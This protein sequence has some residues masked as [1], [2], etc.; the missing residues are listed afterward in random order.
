MEQARAPKIPKE[1]LHVA[2]GYAAIGLVAHILLRGFSFD[3]TSTL[4]YVLGW[5][6][7]VALSL[8]YWTAKTLLW[9]LVPVLLLLSWLARRN[10]KGFALGCLGFAVLLAIA[11]VR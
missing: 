6:I 4:L 5:P 9:C 3:L 2:F 7:P 8:A 11:L 1:V 10:A